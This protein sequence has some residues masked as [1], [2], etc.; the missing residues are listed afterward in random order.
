MLVRSPNAVRFGNVY[1]ANVETIVVERSAHKTIE[2][3]TD[4][5]PHAVFVDVPEQRVSVKL[6]RRLDTGES[7]DRVEFIPG[8][9]GL[10]GFF[11]A[12]H[13]GDA[14]PIEVNITCVLT[15]VRYDAWDEP[16]RQVLTFVAYSESATQDPV[17]V[18]T[19]TRVA[20]A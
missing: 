12:G 2:E 7:P 5:G 3:W 11:L 13:G 1:L 15:G 8:K 17:N 20:S 4:G 14:S 18:L 16:T 10:L 6:V 9:D 19:G